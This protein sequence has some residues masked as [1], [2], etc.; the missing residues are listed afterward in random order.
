[1]PLFIIFITLFQIGYFIYMYKFQYPDPIDS[2]NAWNY[3]FN[4]DK[5]MF[6]GRQT[7]LTGEY[8][9]FFTYS[10]VHW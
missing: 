7:V 5:L 2:W 10:F 3:Q 1:M 6:T 9:R 4:Q 8:W